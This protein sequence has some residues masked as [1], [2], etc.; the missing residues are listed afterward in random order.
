MTEFLCYRPFRLVIVICTTLF[1]TSLNAQD[2]VYPKKGAIARGKIAEVSR[3]EIVLEV[4][5]NKMKFPV[6]EVRKV[7]FEDEP[8]GLD[9]ARELIFQE[10]YPQAIEELKKLD[11]KN[12]KS[13]A[14]AQDI[15]FYYYFSEGKQALAGLGGNKERAYNGLLAL[16]KKNNKSHHMYALTMM[17]GDLSAV[18]GKPEAVNYYKLLLASPDPEQKLVGEYRMAQLELTQGKFAEAKARFQ[19]IKKSDVDTPEIIRIKNFA[20]VGQALCSVKEGNAKEAIGELKQLAQKFDNSD[21]EL[22]AKIYI[23]EGACHL[24]LNETL[25]AVLSYLKVDLMYSSDAEA[26]AEA[27]YQ[28]SQLWPKAGD[29]SRAAEARARLV[30]KYAGSPWANK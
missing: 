20:E 26:H 3:D 11:P 22:F 23:A 9:K 28:L 24:A 2:K 25:P 12:T 17:L 18:L 30:A 15:E 16:A 27:L 14:I 13:P 7:V 4:G 5:S 19:Q 1:S 8:P 29:P 21:Q 10:Q 6:A